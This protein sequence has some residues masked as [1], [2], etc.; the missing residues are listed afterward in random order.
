MH[1]QTLNFQILENTFEFGLNS[2]N[3]QA[4][5]IFLAQSPNRFYKGLQSSRTDKVRF[6]HIEDNLFPYEMTKANLA[7]AL[8]L[9][10]VQWTLNGNNRNFALIFQLRFHENSFDRHFSDISLSV[11]L[12]TVLRWTLG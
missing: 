12:D 11:D 4:V 3:F 6:L 7:K 10:N 2:D 9:F 8:R 1:L 5:L